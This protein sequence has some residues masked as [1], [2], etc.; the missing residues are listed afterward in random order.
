MSIYG[1]FREK[2]IGYFM[3]KK[4]RK[5]DT[6]RE[7]VKGEIIDDEAKGRRVILKR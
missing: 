2:K 7:R 5:K 6:K 1:D 3:M 4:K